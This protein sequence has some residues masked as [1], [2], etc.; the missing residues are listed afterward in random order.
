MLTQLIA[1][2]ANNFSH[3]FIKFFGETDNHLFLS[4]YVL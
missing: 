3:Y 1:K 4:L 2:S